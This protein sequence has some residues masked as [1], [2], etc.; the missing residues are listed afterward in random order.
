MVE[1]VVSG[2]ADK[3]IRPWAPPRSYWHPYESVNI[4]AISG[5]REHVYTSVNGRVKKVYIGIAT[6]LDSSTI[7]ALTDAGFTATP[8]GGD[9]S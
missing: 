2:V 7:S 4:S 1:V 6:D 5:E 8:V 9:G 3:T